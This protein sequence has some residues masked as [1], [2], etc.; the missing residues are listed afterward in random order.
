MIEI[1]FWQSAAAGAILAAF[2]TA[3]SSWLQRRRDDRIESRR[4]RREAGVAGIEAAYRYRAAINQVAS[5]AAIIDTTGQGTSE[6]TA[7]RRLEAYSAALS[8]WRATWEE[9]GSAAMTARAVAAPGVDL[10]LA[11]MADAGISWQSSLAERS[12]QK[13]ISD[14]HQ[15]RL[16][17]LL[18]ELT[19]IVRSDAKTDL[20]TSILGRV[21]SRRSGSKR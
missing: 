8:E 7:R 3:M 18:N 9:M 17:S 20:G 12:F 13:D 15:A 10:V 11:S 4:S 19:H 6:E 21:K 5:R 16:D 2:I 1:P 14:E